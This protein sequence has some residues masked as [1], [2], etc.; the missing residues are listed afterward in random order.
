VLPAARTSSWF[1]LVA[2]VV[3]EACAPGAESREARVVEALTR[4]DESLLRTRPLL[5]SGKYRRMSEDAVAYMRGS[6]AITVRDWSDGRPVATASRFAVASPRVPSL[7]DAHPENFGILWSAGPD[8]SLEEEASFEPNDFDAA[9]DLPY[10]VDLRVLA[11]RL[12]LR[13]RR[14]P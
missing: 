12:Q 2:L 4:A 14:R 7:G 5:V 3:L 6:L 9:D 8:L 13:R 10:L 11:G 1:A